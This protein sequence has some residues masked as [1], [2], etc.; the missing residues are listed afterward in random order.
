MKTKTLAIGAVIIC[1]IVILSGCTS[2]TSEL[3]ETT[4]SIGNPAIGE[5]DI[6]YTA[7]GE[8]AGFGA[9]HRYFTNPDGQTPSRGDYN[10]PSKVFASLPVIPNDFNEIVYL[11]KMGKYFDIDTLG[12]EYYLQPEFYGNWDNGIKFWTNPDPAHWCT[13]GYGS[14]PADQFVDIMR[15]ESMNLTFFLRSSYCVQTYQGVKLKHSFPEMALSG[16]GITFT[17]AT[18]NPERWIDVSISPD[19]FLLEP[20]Y[21]QFS[22]GWVKKIQVTITTDKDTPKGE[23]I[24]G[25]DPKQ[26]DSAIEKE[27]Y[28]EYLNMYTSGTGGVSIGRSWE[29]LFVRIL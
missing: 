1:M 15:G 11:I 3:I 21:P 22:E 28:R 17:R 12:D 6:E 18:S 14:Y 16:D 27:W 13:I 24:I 8:F 5:G 20:N 7:D 29:Q 23:Y 10:I 4:T 25:I 26:P 19:Q 2:T 9:R